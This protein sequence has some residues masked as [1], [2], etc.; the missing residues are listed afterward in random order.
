MFVCTGL[1]FA[2]TFNKE[3]NYLFVCSGRTIAGY[4][5]TLIRIWRDDKL[6]PSIRNYVGIIK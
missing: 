2:L 4:V 6:Q 1:D 5:I 3:N